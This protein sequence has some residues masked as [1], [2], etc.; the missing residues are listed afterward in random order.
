[1]V[2]GV[3]PAFSAIIGTVT[4][5]RSIAVRRSCTARAL[6]SGSAHYTP[7]PLYIVGVILMLGAEFNAAI[8]K[9]K[10]YSVVKQVE[11]QRTFKSARPTPS[12]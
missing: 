9:Y 11:R 10:V 4:S 6:L 1:M 8:L 12:R 7:L 5:A 3:T 2:D